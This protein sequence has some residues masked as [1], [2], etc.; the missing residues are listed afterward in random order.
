MCGFIGHISFD[1]TFINKSRLVD[2]VN[3]IKSRGPDNLGIAV[4]NNY[5]F[6]FRRLS[7]IDLSNDANQPMFSND[8]NYVCVFN[9]EIYNYKELYNSIKSEFVWKTNSDTELLINCWI[10]WGPDCLQKLD[11]MFSFAILDKK[12]SLL[13]A[14]RDRVGEKPFYY[15]AINKNIYF[16]SRP[17]PILHQIPE[18]SKEYNEQSIR[19]HLE[20][21]YI[22]GN[23]TIYKSIQKLKAGHYLI[24][25]KNNFDIYPYW[26]IKNINVNVELLKKK[27]E[28]LI[29]ELDDLLT[30]SVEKKFISDVPVGILLS[31]GI[32]SSLITA[33]AKKK[34][35]RKDNIKT[36]SIGFLN[37]NYDESINS[38]KI[39]NFLGTDHNEKKISPND[40]LD[41]LPKFFNN[42]DEPFFDSSSFPMMFVSKIAS[43][44][45]KVV[46]TG[47][48]GDEL[49]GGYNYYLIIKILEKIN[50]FPR[51]V[52]KILANILS[53]S[54]NYK[55]NLI[56]EVLKKDNF[57]DSFAFIR[58]IL[59]INKNVLFESIIKKTLGLNNIFREDYLSFDKNISSAEA[60][61]KL[62]IINTL[63]DDYL[64]KSD[65]SSMSY[66]IENRA[67][68]L[69]KDIIEWSAKLPLKYKINFFNKKHILKK[70]LRRYLPDHLI[71]KKKIGFEVPIREWIIHDLHDWTSE[72]VYNKKF[73]KNLPIKQSLVIELFLNL[74]KGKN[75]IHSY[76]WSILMLLEFNKRNLSLQ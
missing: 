41:L 61:M 24:F 52:K 57:I 62:D 6:A 54:F 9:G 66:S 34:L 43:K 46:L 42:F 38:K 64:Q 67:P 35:N 55:I 14:A 63:N 50:Y 2:S 32:D 27:E 56:A 40:L 51:S 3:I 49:F 75:G 45:V 36:F 69:S 21:G 22:P 4:G 23:N 1:E 60:C 53:K 30:A 28:D 16:S 44:Q 5:G 37:K 71:N 26:E 59:K 18:L 74:K 72:R 7:I 11:G 68:F 20:S 39:A 10:K 76:L 29:D 17:S 31:S 33:I 13:Y 19:S 73:Y 65:L 70:L 58:S 12:N 8:Q 48:G 47:D 25:S 15:Y